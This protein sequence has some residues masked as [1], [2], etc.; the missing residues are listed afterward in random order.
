M[1]EPMRSEGHL[2][3]VTLSISRLSSLVT[4]SRSSAQRQSLLIDSVALVIDASARISPEQTC[5]RPS[6]SYPSP[7]P[8]PVTRPNI[9]TPF[10]SPCPPP[11]HV[12]L[13]PP[14]A[15]ITAASSSSQGATLYSNEI[16]LSPFQEL[17][18]ERPVKKKGGE[19][20]RRNAS[21][22]SHPTEF[23]T[24]ARTRSYHPPS[25]NLIL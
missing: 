2:T 10:S 13:Y 19:R 12:P 9:R 3:M 25:F 18:K 23:S 5:S 8:Y 21:V 16:P 7:L 15:I 6:L 14:P 20:G 24:R 4:V 17:R 1:S 22:C 11:S